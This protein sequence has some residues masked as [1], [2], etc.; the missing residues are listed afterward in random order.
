MIAELVVEN[1]LEKKSSFDRSEGKGSSSA[2]L[3]V[4]DGKAGTRFISIHRGCKR[5]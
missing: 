4:L 2:C 5:F 1:N 3:W